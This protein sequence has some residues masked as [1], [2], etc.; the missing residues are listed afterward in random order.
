MCV[1]VCVYA[2]G[3][4]WLK[5]RRGAGFGFQLGV[6]PFSYLASAC[7]HVYVLSISVCTRASMCVC[8]LTYQ[9]V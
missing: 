2:G 8:M 4:Q 6:A 5:D 1:C 7:G 9:K 3:R